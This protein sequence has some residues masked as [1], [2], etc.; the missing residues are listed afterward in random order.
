MPCYTSYCVACNNA[1]NNSIISQKDYHKNKD[2]EEENKIL[3]KLQKNVDTSWLNNVLVVTEDGKTVYGK[4]KIC[5][6]GIFVGNNNKEYLIGFHYTKEERNDK[7]CSNAVLL[8]EACYKIL[9]NLMTNK[10]LYNIYKYT[11]WGG[12]QFKFSNNYY[13]EMKKIYGNRFSKAQDPEY[14]KY[15]YKK[16]MVIWIMDKKYLYNPL[17]KKGHFLHRYIYK[18]CKNLVKYVSNKRNH[19]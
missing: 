2:I 10:L 17:T 11:V 6:G 16:H 1:S 14:Y 8:H 18:V 12:L 13:K 7:Y 3:T 9:K 15:D 4:D 5:D 19:I